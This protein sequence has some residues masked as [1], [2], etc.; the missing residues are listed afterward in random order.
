MLS[1]GYDHKEKSVR[2]ILL[3]III[4]AHGSDPKARYMPRQTEALLYGVDSC[5]ADMLT[6]QRHL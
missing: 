3:P 6:L 4:G 1:P 5:Y 2:G